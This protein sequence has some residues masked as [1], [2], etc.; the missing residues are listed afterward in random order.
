MSKR[1]KYRYV[2]CNGKAAG[3]AAG[4]LT[5]KFNE[6]EQKGKESAEEI[7]YLLQQKAVHGIY[8]TGSGPN[9]ATAMQAALVLSESCKL[10]FTGMPM[11]QYDHGPKE[12]AKNS[13]VIQVM[14]KGSSYER[15]RQLTETI[16]TAG[17]HVITIE[18]PDATENVSVLH[19]IIPFNFMAYYLSQKLNIKEMF[20]V[21]G[22]VTE[23]NLT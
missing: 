11:A 16:R 15:S 20:V 18:E 22:K 14:A 10:V 3:D 6:Y 1:I 23:V 9:I 12:T 21:G 2:A 19:N 4:L 13:I 5:E 17:A 7:F 8:V